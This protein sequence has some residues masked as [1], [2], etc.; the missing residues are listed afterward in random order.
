MNWHDHEWDA[1]QERL[2]DAADNAAPD[3]GSGL[4]PGDS[5]RLPVEAR[6]ALC[7]LLSGPSVDAQ[8]HSKLWPALLRSEAA[9]RS[10]LADLFLELVLDRDAGIAFTRQADTGELEAPVL[11]RSSPLTFIDSVLLLHLRQQLAEADARGLRAVVEEAQLG[12]ALAV[13]EKNLSTD[14]AGF[15]R[16]VGNAVQKM[17]DNHILTRLRGEDERYE[18]S[19]ALKLLFSAEDVAALAQVYR[20]LREGPGSGEDAAEAAQDA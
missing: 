13:Y 11:L 14:R 9:I 3:A 20:Q 7:Q 12:E 15:L 16:R 10:A 19:P 6:R 18:V 2:P 17:K 1:E 8:R 4:F 5:G